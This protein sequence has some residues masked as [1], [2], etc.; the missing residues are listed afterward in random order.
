MGES[1]KRQQ[2]TFTAATSDKQV[3]SLPH[4]ILSPQLHRLS[5]FDDPSQRHATTASSSTSTSSGGVPP[6]AGPSLPHSSHGRLQQQPQKLPTHVLHP[7]HR[8]PQQHQQQEVQP[9]DQLRGLS[10]RSRT[11]VSHLSTG[12]YPSRAQVKVKCLLSQY[13]NDAFHRNCSNV[14]NR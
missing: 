4:D 14:A 8:L 13:Y 2:S 11:G 9:A 3:F 10:Q 7:Q 5:R 1:A 6:S 12:S